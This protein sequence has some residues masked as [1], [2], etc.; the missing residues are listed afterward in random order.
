MSED[1]VLIEFQK[2]RP[3]LNYDFYS[4]KYGEYSYLA[5]VLKPNGEIL[6]KSTLN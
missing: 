4:D 3:V 2:Y 5:L 6:K 1:A